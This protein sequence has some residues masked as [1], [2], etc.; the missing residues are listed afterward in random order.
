VPK[1]TIT[2]RSPTKGYRR[3]RSNQWRSQAPGHRGLGPGRGG[4]NPSFTVAILHCL[5]LFDTVALLLAWGVH[6]GWLRYWVQPK[7]Q[8]RLH[9]REDQRKGPSDTPEQEPTTKVY[10]ATKPSL[11]SIVV[12]AQATTRKPRIAVHQRHTSPTGHLPIATSC[13]SS[14]K[15]ERGKKSSRQ[16]PKEGNDVE[17]PPPPPPVPLPRS[18]LSPKD[19]GPRIYG[20]RELHGGTSIEDH[21][22]HGRRHRRPASRADLGRSL[23]RPSPRAARDAG[24]QIR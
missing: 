23:D 17:T 1:K 24:P 6:P 8:L 14:P 7:P 16:C 21:D 2:T 3:H 18:R 12:A 19:H 15:H 13:M 10:A 9:N 22:V 11:I 5:T 4:K 20:R